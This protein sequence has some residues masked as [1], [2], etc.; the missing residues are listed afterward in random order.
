MLRWIARLLAWSAVLATMLVAAVLILT[1][2]ALAITPPSTLMLWRQ[3]RGEAVE[4]I[5]VPLDAVSPH[6]VRA[7]IASEDA[8]Y[9][10]H[11]GV[12]FIALGEVLDE[13]DGMPSRGA[14]TITMQTA[15]NVFLWHGRSIVRKAL[16]LPL[17][18]GLDL[19]WG[20]RRTAEIYLNIAEWGE[21]LFGAEAAARRHFGKSARDL[22]RREAALM[23]TAL[24]NPIRRSAG[25]PTAA[26]RRLAAAVE[27]RMVDLGTR[28][29][30]LLAGAATARTGR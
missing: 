13:D 7:I 22:T 15:K 18:L 21:G 23:A 29:D 19:V 20:K 14:S 5:V 2:I 4:R 30:C 25:R 28:A 1:V 3:M 26:H 24:P 11:S 12:D 10:A 9:C 6:L 16:E 17:A 8:R 27:V